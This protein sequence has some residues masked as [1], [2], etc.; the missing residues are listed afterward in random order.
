[1]MSRLRQYFITGLVVW[2]PMGVTVWVLLWLVGILDGIF[3]G[4]LSAL[5]RALP[6]FASTAE[7]LQRVPG[8]GVVLVAIVILATGLFVANM[9]GQWWLR[10]WDR[11]MTHIP[12]VRS[13]YS[14]VKQVSDTLFSGTGQAF[15]KTLLV[16][17][18]HRD[19]WTI[20]F[21]TGA[22]VGEVAER[23]AEQPEA[24]Q[25]LA[26][27]PGAWVSVFVPATPNPT[28]GFF[29]LVPRA[30]VIELHMSVHEALKY[31]ISMGVV[32]PGAEVERGAFGATAHANVPPAL[33]P[34]S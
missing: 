12:V 27:E 33:P 6:G 29:L 15:S 8:L 13:I 9:V 19:A 11:L 21:L 7:S 22:P 31:V 28:S 10:Q 4:V 18:P 26:G 16:R 25:S 14:S 3:G 32:A 23:L 20:A 17:Y 30:D 5:A 34:H 1:M 24:S 2:L